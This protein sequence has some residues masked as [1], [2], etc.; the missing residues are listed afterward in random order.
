[1]SCMW[2]ALH[3]SHL[4]SVAFHASQTTD[5]TPET[6]RPMPDTTSTV[7]STFPCAVNFADGRFLEYRVTAGGAVCQVVRSIDLGRHQRDVQRPDRQPR[8]S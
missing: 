6:L 5:E 7:W 2:V 4:R 8:G 3:L 1:M